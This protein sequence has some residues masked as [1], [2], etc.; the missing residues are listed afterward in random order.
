MKRLLRTAESVKYVATSPVWIREMG[1][2]DELDNYSSD[3]LG[4]DLVSDLVE[5]VDEDMK[6]IGPKGLA[7]YSDDR[8]SD[9]VESII[10]KFENKTGKTYINCTREL[11]NEE[12]EQLKDYITGQFSDGWGEGFEQ[13]PFSSFDTEVSYEEYD[14]EEQESYTEYVT[15]KAELYASFWDVK[16]SWNI[17]LERI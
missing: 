15:E 2:N 4:S 9:A 7:E 11:T 3:V 1:E 6:S 16:N 13:Q 10:V 8:V 14:E 5:A 12:E 17:K